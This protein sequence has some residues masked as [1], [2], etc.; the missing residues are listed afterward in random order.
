MNKNQPLIIKG[1]KILHKNKWLI[2]NYIMISSDGKIKEIGNINN[3]DKLNLNNYEIYNY[4]KSDYLIPGLIDCHMHGAS[5]Y[6]VM[7]ADLKGLEII[8]ESLLKQGTTGFLATTMT[9]SDSCIEKALKAVADYQ[10]KYK[11][12]EI[13]KLGAQI[14]GVHLEGPF[15]SNKHPG[16][17]NAKY[18][19][20]ADIKLFD[21]WQ[22]ISNNQ[23]KLV[24][25]APE[26]FNNMDFIK[27]VKK[28]YP[29]IVISIGHSDASFEQANEAIKAGACHC[30][31][32]YNAMSSFHHRKPGI[33]G[34][35]LVSDDIMAELIVDGVHLHPGSVKLAIKA[36][37][38]DKLILVTDAMRARCMGNGEF[39]LGGQKVV[40]K[41]M[42]ASLE[43]GVL[44]GSVLSQYQ[45]LKLFANQTGLDLSSAV[46]LSAEN[47][48]KQLN[49][50]NK[51]GSLDIGKIANLIILSSEMAV[52]NVYLSGNNII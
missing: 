5:G 41:D 43:G 34:A 17:Q 16:A 38:L 9:M 23:I 39:D 33:P 25:I 18:I 37:G 35:V 46:K 31:H 13:G 6:D 26:S 14:L 10:D 24:T 32:L 21:K 52:K 27:H 29:D 50:Y 28:H 45:A 47:P 20:A 42:N 4:D 11:K 51:Y 40:V 49:I 19:K 7:D 30:T 3:L 22:D 8:A 48:A 12:G 44:A 36:K 15:L 2:D 1:C